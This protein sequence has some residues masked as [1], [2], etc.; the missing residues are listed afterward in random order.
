MPM[1]DAPAPPEL[2]KF[3]SADAVLEDPLELVKNGSS[4]DAALED[5]PPAPPELMKH[6]SAPAS[7]VNDVP[8]GLEL[9]PAAPLPGY[10]QVFVGTKVD[11]AA[12]L[13]EGNPLRIDAI[14]NCARDDW[15]D[16]V[17]RGK[18]GAAA[19]AAHSGLKKEIEHMA[20]DPV[21]GVACGEVRGITYCTFNARDRDRIDPIIIGNEVAVPGLEAY[22]ASQHFPGALRFI[23]EQRALDRRLLIHC[24]RGE[25]RAGSIAVA[26]LAVDGGQPVE[27]AVENV[28]RVRG[29]AALSN[30]AFVE[31]V[32]E[33]AAKAHEAGA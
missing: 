20:D 19:Q 28:Q 21:G 9:V 2:V 7:V 13:C 16:Q 18:C 32:A 10:P 26:F 33:F 31:Q 5:E 11:A 6:A 25:N 8:F 1:G 15:L 4:A 23:R 3:A 30:R 29:Y 17:K 12:A 24:L 27:E 14:V 22:D